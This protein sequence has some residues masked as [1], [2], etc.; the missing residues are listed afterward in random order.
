MS[1]PLEALDGNS[2]YLL[3]APDE[4]PAGKSRPI[5]SLGFIRGGFSGGRSPRTTRKSRTFG[6]A[7]GIFGAAGI[8]GP[9][10]SEFSAAGPT[11]LDFGGS[12]NRRLSEL[13]IIVR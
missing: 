5:M 4:P 1:Q 6:P 8:R 2:L 11:I 10:N 12:P 7:D 3:A 9:R 13:C